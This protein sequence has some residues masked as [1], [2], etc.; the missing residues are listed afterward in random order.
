MCSDPL[1]NP[2]AHDVCSVRK[3]V[4]KLVNL[5]EP[6]PI[7]ILGVT[8]IPSS[9]TV[10]IN[11]PNIKPSFALVLLL[12]IA[13]MSAAYGSPQQLCWLPTSPKDPMIT[14]L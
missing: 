1:V 12:R 14:Y 11:S 7:Q 4:H 2:P 3:P 8:V 6:I 13:L 5:S 10:I 9:S